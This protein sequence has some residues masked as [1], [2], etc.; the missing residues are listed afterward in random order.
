VAQGKVIP[1]SR[2]RA[3]YEVAGWDGVRWVLEGVFES[4]PEAAYQAK[5]V[6]ARRLGVRVTQEVFSEADGVFKSRVLFTEFRDPSAKATAPAAAPAP[7]PPAAAAPPA[8][9]VFHP[10]PRPV[11]PAAPRAPR[12]ASRGAG[13]PKVESR[14]TAIIIAISSLAISI[15]TMLLSLMR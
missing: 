4:G 14:D 15:A 8:R 2:R 12:P 5:Q 10:L 3:G 9:P 13:A 1:S 7:P 6:L 11:S